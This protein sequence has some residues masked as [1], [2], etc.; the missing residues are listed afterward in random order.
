LIKK[1]YPFEIHKKRE[2]RISA[3]EKGYEWKMIFSQFVIVWF[4]GG[5]AV[6]ITIMA[7]ITIANIASF[8]ILYVSPLFAFRG[9]KEG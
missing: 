7:N 8:A 5:T 1:A 9:S 2:R 3:T 6:A 4:I